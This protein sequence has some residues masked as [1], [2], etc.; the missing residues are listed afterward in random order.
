MDAV[1]YG[2][3]TS[4][5]EKIILFDNDIRPNS[6]NIERIC[7]DLDKFSIVKCIVDFIKPKFFDCVDLAGIYTYNRL[8][9]FGQTW[10]NI[11]FRKSILMTKGFPDS[12]VLYDE[13]AIERRIRDGSNHH[14][15]SLPPIP[16]RSER[17][18]RIVLNQRLRYAYENIALPLRFVCDLL[19][20][21]VLGIAAIH[22]T[23]STAIALAVVI[24][25]FIW[26]ASYSY[27]S[28][29]GYTPQAGTVWPLAPLW[30]WC[31][32]FCSW[33][34]AILY[35]FGFGVRFH[36]KRIQKPA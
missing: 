22:G 10:G 19:V 21:P 7:E 6:E 34:A 17:S 24:T 8:S 25:T 14:Y 13:L 12:D 23:L 18:L 29:L 33:Y 27:Q 5:T 2:L 16:M 9:K 26:W 36:H 11:S 15:R 28:R 4:K 30:Y 3:T 31:Y 32:P 35:V 1:R 20:L